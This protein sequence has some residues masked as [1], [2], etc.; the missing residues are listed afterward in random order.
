MPK[1][2]WVLLPTI[3]Y[4]AGLAARML[5]RR[6]RPSR[7]ALNL[8]LSLLL[9]LYLAATAG[10]GLFWVA[11]Q[12]LPVFDWHYL[13]GYGTLAL[14]LIHLY[15]NLPA[16]LQ[17][18]RR[19]PHAAA[20]PPAG[21][22]RGR[23][24]GMAAAMAAALVAAWWLG[25]G[26]QVARHAPLASLPA[27]SP[28]VEAVLRYHADSSASRRQVLD[29]APALDW[30]QAPPAFKAYP[31]A[32][33]IRLSRGDVGWRGL[34]AALGGAGA[35]T[36]ALRLPELGDLLYLSAGV[37]GRREGGRALRAAPSAGALFSS[38][39]YLLVRAVQGLAPGVYHYDAD[40]ERLDVL[41]P[42]PADSGA[43]FAD[44]A[45]AA[46]VLTSVIRRTAYKYGDRAYRYVAAD[47]GH[48]LENLRVASQSAGMRATLAA[49]FDEGRLA[50]ALGVDG[51]D[52]IVLAVMEL[53]RAGAAPAQAWP[54]RYAELAAGPA[55]APDVTAMVQRATS[56]RLAD[57]E[58][59]RDRADVV[60]LP[61]PQ[62]SAVPVRQVIVERRSKRRFT[63]EP[64]PLA[65][66]AGMLADLVQPDQLSGAVRIS[67]VVN[68]VQGLA[69]GIYR[70]D[71]RQALRRVRAG[72]FSAAAEQAALSQ[73][74][75]GDAAVVLVLSV[76]RGALLAEGAR[77]YRHGLLETGLIGERWLL[78]AVGRH[79]GA[80]PVGAF[81]DDEAAALIDADPQREWVLHF[82]A[83]GV[84]AGE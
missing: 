65:A 35:R 15:F 1:L 76:E 64:V 83:L 31:A 9:M 20:S 19:P 44:H 78:G 11:R 18:L 47:G 53:R 28:N 25:A 46:I 21:R 29:R 14:A 22:G 32:A 69:P 4:A 33:H 51:D 34:S 82:A 23:R 42:L 70:Y 38:E 63:G 81:Y 2:A 75:V 8:Q 56:L 37:T 49:R 17:A 10:L 55:P 60:T 54:P 36:D 16:A 61:A 80:C 84:P 12:Q 74:V 62:A 5:L 27:A 39:L 66:L 40:Q 43:P 57:A 77:G 45:D 41:G 48:L 13:F 71:R 3:L 67:L 58:A 59:G 73:S 72:Q 52:E 50:H 68:R 24:A 79:L 26:W 6:G 30:G 7:Q